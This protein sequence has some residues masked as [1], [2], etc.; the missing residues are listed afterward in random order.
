RARARTPITARFRNPIAMEDAL[1]LLAEMAG[2]EVDLRENTLIVT[3]G[4][5]REG[6][7]KRVLR[8][9]AR[10]LHQALR[11]LERWS[12]VHVV[13][14]P[15]FEPDAEDELTELARLVLPED[16]EKQGTL[17]SGTFAPGVST[18]AAARV[19]ANQAELVVV[20]VDG[21]LYVTEALSAQHLLENA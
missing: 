2:L 12:G 4:E 6:A 5:K 18:E 7:A 1:R 13:L 21:V 20:N 11:D 19:L 3:T 16:R 17:V 14:D 15:R 10:P 9:R 8:I